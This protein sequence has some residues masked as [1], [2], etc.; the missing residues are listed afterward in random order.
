MEYIK[1]AEHLIIDGNMAENWRFFGKVSKLLQQRSSQI[2]SNSSNS[3]DK[4]Y[5][6]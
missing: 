1:K 4:V 5:A 6:S 2:S 3:A